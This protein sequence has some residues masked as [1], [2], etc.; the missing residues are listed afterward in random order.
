MRRF[1]LPLYTLVLTLLGMQISSATPATDWLTLQ[2]N[3]DGSIADFED[4]ANSGQSTNEALLALS[5]ADTLDRI[6]SQAAVASF[7]D[8]TFSIENVIRKSL[9]ELLLNGEGA[10]D[11]SQILEY[12]NPADGGFKFLMGYSSDILSTS[13]ALNAIEANSSQ[14]AQGAILY[15]LNQQANNGGWALSE[16]NSV[17]VEVTSYA[18]QALWRFRKIF[19]LDS[20]IAE[21]RTFLLSQASGANSLWASTEESALAL[22]ALLITSIDR[23]EFGARVNSLRS[24]LSSNGSFNGDVYLTALISQVLSLAEQPAEDSTLVSGRVVDAETRLPLTAA[25]VTLGRDGANLSLALSDEGEFQSENLEAGRYELQIQL[26]GYDSILSELQLSQSQKLDLGDLLLRQSVEEPTVTFVIGTIRETDTGNPLAGVVVEETVSS[27]ATTT[28]QSGEYQLVLPSEGAIE[29]TATL[30]GFTDVSGSATVNF[31]ETLVFSPTLANIASQ[32][33]NVFGIITDSETG[34][35]VVGAEIAIQSD[36]QSKLAITDALGEYRLEDIQSG[37][38]SLTVRATGYQPITGQAAIAA[39]SSINFSPSIVPEGAQP[40]DIATNTVRGRV[41]DQQSGEALQGVSVTTYVEN[42]G[43]VS[44]STDLNGDFAVTGI[45]PGNSFTQISFSGYQT[46]SFR[47]DAGLPNTELSLETI[48]LLRVDPVG[49]YKLNGRVVDSVSNAALEG[50]SITVYDQEMMQADIIASTTSDANGFYTFDDVPR[51]T[52]VEFSLAEYDSESYSTIY[53]QPESRTLTDI[54]LSKVEIESFLPD[55]TAQPFDA[56]SII[57]DI[58]TNTVAGSLPI[59]I[60]NVGNSDSVGGFE[61]IA[62]QDINSDGIYTPSSD[63]TLGTLLVSD[64]I[65]SGSSIESVVDINGTLSFRDAPISIQIDWSNIVVESDEGNNTVVSSGQCRFESIC[66][67]DVVPLGSP[68]LKFAWDGAGSSFPEFNQVTMLPLVAQANDDNGDGVIDALDTPDIFFTAASVGTSTGGAAAGYVRIIS[69]ED[70]TEIRTFSEIGPVVEAY[71]SLALGDIDSDGEIE[72][73]AA[74]HTTGIYAYELD[75][76]LKWYQPNTPSI[77]YGGITL[78]DLDGNGEVEIL[79]AG[80]ALSSEGEVLWQSD[81]FEGQ[82]G[83]GSRVIY[84]GTVPIAVDVNLDGIQEVIYGGTAFKYTGEQL[85]QNATVKDGLNAIGNFDDDENPEVVVVKNGRIVLIDHTGET[86]WTT[87]TVNGEGGAPTVAD[88]D[89]DGQVEIGIAGSTY[90]AVYDTNGSLLWRA[91]TFDTSSRA[92]G[93]SVFDFNN[94]GNP[95]VVYADERNLHVFNG[96]DGSSVFTLPHS[97]ATTY[98]YPVVADVDNDNSAE[99]VVALNNIFRPGP[100]PGVGIRVYKEANDSWVGTRSIWNQ[101]AYSIDNVNDD[102]SIPSNPA[103]S[104][105]THN[106][107]R[108][109]SFPE[110]AEAANQAR[111]EIYLNDSLITVDLI[112]GQAAEPF[113]NRSTVDSLA[114]VIDAQTAQTLEDHT[115]STHVWVKGGSLGLRFDFQTEYDLRTIHFWNYFS[116]DFDVDNIDF[117]FFN[118]DNELVGTLEGIQPRLGGSGGNPISAEDIQLPAPANVR[119]LEATLSGTNGEVDF[120]NIGF[121]AV[122]SLPRATGDESDYS[123]SRMTLAYNRTSGLTD[124]STRIGNAG[125]KP[126]ASVNEPPISL[127]L[128]GNDYLL[129]NNIEPVFEH[130]IEFWLRVPAGDTAPQNNLGGPGPGGI[131]QLNGPFACG[132]GSLFRVDANRILTWYV[133]PAGCGG[134]NTSRLNG[135][136]INDEWNHVVGT[137]D[138]SVA[139]F[140]FN[141]E[142]ID[143]SPAGYTPS[144]NLIFGTDSFAPFRSFLRAD[145][146]EVRL[147]RRALSQEEISARICTEL[148]GTEDGLSLYWPLNEAEG[149]RVIDQS[150]SGLDTNFPLGD[151]APSWLVDETPRAFCGPKSKKVKVT[152]YKGDPKSGG[153]ELETKEITAP[154]AGEFIDITFENIGGLENA[155][156]VY[157]VV[158][159]DNIFAECDESNNVI[160]KSLDGIVTSIAI[161]GTVRDFL[162]SHPDFEQGI[163]S[164]DLDIVLDQLGSDDK[165]VYAGN[166]STETTNGR[167]FFDQWYRNVDGVNLAEDLTIILELDPA[168]GMFIYSSDEF[169]PIDNRLFGNQIR[170]H[171]H[172]FTYE[173]N[174]DFVY[175]GG[176]EFTFTGDDDLWLFIDGSLVVNLGGVHGPL[177][178]TIKL[179]DIAS[180]LGLQVGERYSFDLF[181]AERQTSNSSFIIETSIAIGLDPFLD[182]ALEVTAVEPTVV[183]GDTFQ[184]VA[185]VQN[186]GNTAGDIV[187]QQT[188][189]DS[190][191][192]TVFSFPEETFAALAP[193]GI[194]SVDAQW[195]TQDILTGQYS[196]VSVAL[197]AEGETLVQVDT[198]FALVEAASAS[199]SIRVSTDK[200]VY[201]IT[202]SVG[203]ETLTQS[204]LVGTVI[205]DAVVLI[206]V[207][208]DNFQPVFTNSM[209]LGDISASGSRI[210]NTAYA[211]D[212]IAGL[213]SYSVVAKLLDAN[214]QILA[215]NVT[216]FLVENQLGIALAGT[217]TLSA[218]EVEAGT[219]ITC[220]DILQNQS[221]FDLQNVE[222]RQL[223][224]DLEREEIVNSDVSTVNVAANNELA[225][226]VRGIKTEELLIGTHSCALQAFIGQEWVTFDNQVFEVFEPPIKIEL[227]AAAG[228]KGRVLVLLDNSAQCTDEPFGPRNTPD[229]ATQQAFLE[230]VLSNAGW[231]YTITL[232]DRDFTRELRTGGYGSYL[233]LAEIE[234]LSHFAQKELREAVYRGEGLIE[235]G[236]RLQP[237]EVVGSALGIQHRGQDHRAQGIELL[238]GELGSE[239]SILFSHRDRNIKIATQG[240]KLI[241]EYLNGQA[242]TPKHKSGKQPSQSRFSKKHYL[243]W[244]PPVP[245]TAPAI[246]LNEYGLGKAIFM[247]FDL[248][249]EA[250]TLGGESNL[251]SELLLKALSTVNPDPPL[252]TIG[253][254][255]PLVFTISNIG[256]ATPATLLLPLPD[257]VSVVDAG[258]GVIDAEAQTISWT[259]NLEEA[260]VVEI[261]VWVEMPSADV[262]LRASVI[263]GEEPSQVEQASASIR[264][265]PE[266]AMSFEDVIESTTQARAL[267]K[268]KKSVRY[269]RWYQ[270][271]GHTEHALRSLLIAA[272]HVAHIQKHYQSDNLTALRVNIGL[273]IRQTAKQLVVNE[274]SHRCIMRGSWGNYHYPRYPKSCRYNHWNSRHHKSKGYKFSAQKEL[275]LSQDHEGR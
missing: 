115:Q 191:G 210:N 24:S 179:D 99:I 132:Q 42:Q 21:A 105:L 237:H 101:H 12:Q 97:S 170:S 272:N 72:V 217:I 245:K 107:F 266:Q 275:D 263:T 19:N 11:D 145:I 167:P 8:Q 244:W 55:L 137:Y 102:G 13:L 174:S 161:T 232:N 138:G 182:A 197:N 25:S 106:S 95:E 205:K 127:M 117:K 149:T 94:D 256:N 76:T 270:D 131:G 39:K 195:S 32:Y 110:C 212:L 225:L 34:N 192:N 240:A 2:Q 165:P 29:L 142:F 22:R 108:L 119:Y 77:F 271:K 91:A 172:H 66:S 155:D 121:T 73:L 128:D 152:A 90:Y 177:S 216:N 241:A 56:S 159:S 214:G 31:G 158:D 236:K 147:W 218:D 188:V 259:L 220:S 82:F 154:A 140:Y 261:P 9:S 78:A 57:Q 207:Y 184:A 221:S 199:T 185:M 50:V 268:V 37:D 53:S 252:T 228:E 80:A 65:A 35:A 264:L 122:K 40:G 20:S 219:K 133:D 251:F 26:P 227:T 274:G 223:L 10:R 187:V 51:V 43:S 112:E 130:T 246:T 226:D 135:V 104:W 160:S 144:T 181:F 75:G 16:I 231:S 254:D 193:D 67:L 3:A 186:T 87:N 1:K 163:G 201:D 267:K 45:Q 249:S 150:P 247:G 224:V 190:S 153:I 17:S 230:S 173:I 14:S 175:R 38:V 234:R 157:V 63:N 168:S 258:I 169:F 180:G 134:V 49:A 156:Q 69:G 59:T 79:A 71:A 92:T 213:G 68:E 100:T 113:E 111:E 171:N 141:G 183:I 265:S 194:V 109:N 204:T 255:Y 126:N 44:S 41:I 54:R 74:A 58:D 103:K 47:T 202:E 273:L 116:E 146:D 46:Q 120:N 211:L 28:N 4:V 208:N 253:S 148:D 61:L 86:I 15:L 124:I 262:T 222:I 7:S 229:L 125:I 18:L 96:F 60:E 235:A 93:S 6:D 143:E 52:R 215:E 5:L 238:E 243:N 27:V 139:R 248:L 233:L 239:N 198:P 250:S 88:F 30:N 164:V 151:A 64:S 162:D 118:N 98:E 85:W 48:E 114:S 166:P 257:N 242:S 70:G 176:E 62:Y 81:V 89:N 84:R 269:A 200:P 136:E 260:E 178:S 209:S 203:L 123:V 189:V 196:L 206:E 33:A 83:T 36:T 129:V 23:D